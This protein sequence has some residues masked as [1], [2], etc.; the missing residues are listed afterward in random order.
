MPRKRTTFYEIPVEQLG[1][2]EARAELQELADLIA[3]HDR[4]YHEHDRPAI[5]A[6]EYDALRRRNAAI[7]AR[8]PQL[9][10]PES[11]SRR[12]GGAPAACIAPQHPAT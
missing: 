3:R 10:L 6:A 5:S 2:P 8:F 1:E 12:I 7:E 4:L 9:T 11:P